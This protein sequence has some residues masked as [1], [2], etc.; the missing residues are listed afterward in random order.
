MSS[1]LE[2]PD[3][4]RFY[5]ESVEPLIANVEQ[6]GEYLYFL[7]RCPISHFEVSAKIRPGDERS[8]HLS[9]ALTGNPRLAGLLENALRSKQGSGDGGSYSVEEIEEAACDAF[10]SVSKDFFWDG[11]RWTHWEAEDRVLQFL[12]YGEQLED[13]DSE[14]RGV[15]RRVLVG[16]AKSDGKVEASEKELLDSLLGSG[17][18]TDGAGGL[19]S[20]SELRKLKTRTVAAAVVCLGYAVACVDG[21]LEPSEE[22]VLSSVCEAVG[23]GT[24][25][26]WELKRTAQ[27]FVVDEALARIYGGGSATNE[28]RLE[29]YKFGRG[30][31]L[32]I[33]DLRDLEWR[34][35]RR[36]G[37]STEHR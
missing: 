8:D 18:S 5:I 13:L 10:E 16:V 2:H 6:K 15:L 20:P 19:P 30:L 17:A 36:T 24:L 32:S 1:I 7:F 4:E 34:F 12:N 27:A 33:S 23:L 11:T 37:L 35:L 28:E 21:S 26:Q 29:V 25:K 3:D 9:P 22:N 14:Q 31:G